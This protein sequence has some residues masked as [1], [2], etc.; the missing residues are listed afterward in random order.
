M[1]ASTSSMSVSS[2]LHPDIMVQYLK[3]LGVTP[4]TTRAIRDEVMAQCCGICIIQR[5]WFVCRA[6]LCT[7]SD[8]VI[9]AG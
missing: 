3:S 6:G 5:P 7:A 1:S 2:D 4:E 8:S 9:I